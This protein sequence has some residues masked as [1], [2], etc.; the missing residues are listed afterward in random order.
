MLFLY[1]DFS[2]V[3][4]DTVVNVA[5]DARQPV[6]GAGIDRVLEA[7]DGGLTGELA[8]G[9]GQP[10]ADVLEQRIGAQVVGIILVF[11]AAGDLV[12]PLRHERGEGMLAPPPAPVRNHRRQPGGQVGGGVSLGQPGQ[13]A[14]T[15]QATPQEVDLERDR[16]ERGK[17]GSGC[18]R[19]GLAG[20]LQYGN[21]SASSP[22]QSC[23]PLSRS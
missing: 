10:A 12:D 18:G 9:L 20:H 21:G 8:S 17:H 22:Y 11:V 14:V 5:E 3:D 16:T 19:L 6:A 15:G 4:G 2:M 1:S 7:R 23:A 13:T